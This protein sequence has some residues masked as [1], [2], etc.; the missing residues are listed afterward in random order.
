[1]EHLSWED[2]HG[3]TV[4]KVKFDGRVIM[5]EHDVIMEKNY[6]YVDFYGS[7]G[8]AENESW[9]FES[10]AIR[11]V[12]RIYYPNAKESMRVQRLVFYA[13]S[14][15]TMS[16]TVEGLGRDF[17]I[18]IT[19]INLRSLESFKSDGKDGS[20]KL[21]IIDPGHGGK[22]M[23]AK[24]S[25][26]IGGRD[27]YEK[28]VVLDI[29]RRVKKLI[30]ASPNMK[31]LLTRSNDSYVSLEDRI[32][33]ADRAKGDLFV[34]VHLNATGAKTKSARGFEV[35]YLSDGR[36]ATDRQ[37]EDLENENGSHTSL[38]AGGGGGDVKA[39]LSNLSEEKIQQ[40][41]RESMMLSR[42]FDQLM[43]REGPFR[44]NVRGVKPANF[45]VLMNYNMP[46]VLLECGF[47]DNAQDAS[48]LIQ[49]KTQDQIAALIFN[50]V[51]MYFARTD[52]SF[53]PHLVKVP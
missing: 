31:V 23:G 41:R 42:F 49:S 18:S 33:F 17:T 5:R 21:V 36:K 35:Y 47:I 4:F 1:M 28:D 2:D 43:R 38:S 45:R 40:R 34:S 27:Y 13:R 16:Y 46:S 8:P 15:Y 37:L 3:T 12:K 53:K 32:D 25:K 39:I 6:F 9:D 29:S 26:K 52:P 10:S 44:A 22:S 48:M 20:R 7:S 19:G 30:D 51:N 14:D 50:A 24:T 11:H